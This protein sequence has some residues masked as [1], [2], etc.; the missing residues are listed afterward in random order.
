MWLFDLIMKKL[1]KEQKFIWKY[2]SRIS[3][4]GPPN[5][6]DSWLQVKQRI[7]ISDQ[8]TERKFSLPTKH[9]IS[10]QPQ[11]TYAVALTVMA[12]LFIPFAYQYFNTE[13][14]IQLIFSIQPTFTWPHYRTG[15]STF[16]NL[17]PI[18]Q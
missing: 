15:T 11:I 4:P 18:T 10:W 16:F 2:S 17:L 8:K 13:H 3:L 7:T 9:L 1:D 5:R 6:D 12:I 14:I